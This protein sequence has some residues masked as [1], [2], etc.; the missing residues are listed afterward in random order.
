MTDPD[1]TWPYW[2]D[3]L[4]NLIYPGDH[5]AV[6]T[7]NGRSPQTVIARVVRINR[8]NSKGEE[9]TGR[10]WVDHENPIE[11]ERTGGGTYWERGEYRIS[12]SCTIT[13]VPV[14]DARN[15]FRWT[16]RDGTEPKA[17][18]YQIAANCVKV[19]LNVTESL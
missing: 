7:I 19:E 2:T 6:S 4:G 1:K 8:L 13:A 3:I 9:I 11:K 10:E 15:F 17:V 18:T 5:I 14:I 16:G 12:S